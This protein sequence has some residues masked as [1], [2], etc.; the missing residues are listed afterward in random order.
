MKKMENKDIK[1]IT[2]DRDELLS[3]FDRIDSDLFRELQSAFKNEILHPHENSGFYK[4]YSEAMKKAYSIFSADSDIDDVEFL[5]KQ[6][7]IKSEFQRLKILVKRY[8]VELD[9]D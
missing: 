2:K 3:Q 4:G 9:C 7:A 6:A 8:E 1:V 5:E